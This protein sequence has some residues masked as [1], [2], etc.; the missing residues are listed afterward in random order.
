[1]D[2]FHFTTVSSSFEFGI[3][4]PMI[5]KS[6]KYFSSLSGQFQL[7]QTN[8][9]GCVIENLQNSVYVVNGHFLRNPD[10]C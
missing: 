5:A 10:R 1:M 4:N 9:Q 2:L 6:C 8:L 7:I 3:S